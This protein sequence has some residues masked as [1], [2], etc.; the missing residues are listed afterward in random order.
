[1]ADAPGGKSPSGRGYPPV[2][3]RVLTGF[4]VF[5]PLPTV[6]VMDLAS[7]PAVAVLTG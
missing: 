3:I 2:A 4:L 1:V 5:G 6:N 7:L